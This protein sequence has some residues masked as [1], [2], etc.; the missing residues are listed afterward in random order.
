MSRKPFFRAVAI[1]AALFVIGEG[2]FAAFATTV[3]PTYT[4]HW[5]DTLWGISQRYGVSMSQLA[6]A[7]GMQVN[8]LLLTGR[9]LVL[10]TAAA[11]AATPAPAAP[12]TA[13]APSVAASQAALSQ[14][15][16]PAAGAAATGGAVAPVLPNAAQYA[17]Q[18]AFCSSF[19]PAASP[20]G[21]L[22]Y[23][24][25]ISPSRLAL[26]PIFVQWAEANGI[27]A[28]LVEAIA[29]Q[30]SGWQQSAVSNVG[31]IG[32]GQLMPGTA[33]FIS[34]DLIGDPSLQSSDPTD[35]IRM[36]A[37]LLGY[38]YKSTGGNLCQTVAG[39]YQGL[40]NVL[41]YGVIPDSQAY[42]ANVLSLQLRFQ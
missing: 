5:G 27:P 18:Q 36:S 40:R 25:Q 8:D 16:M 28:S 19:V 2:G 22:P 33:Q 30:E 3:P 29:W 12:A 32:I 17:Q 38:L 14:N 4:V 34:M 26:R 9:T 41:L 31:A 35:N 39:Y 10:P 21:V 24:L 7:N 20:V 42:V 37:R 1:A 23:L 13:A 15:D 11:P 6:A